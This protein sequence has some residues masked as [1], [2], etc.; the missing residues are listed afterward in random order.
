MADFDW[1]GALTGLSNLYGNYQGAQTANNINNSVQGMLGQNAS[2]TAN[3]IGNISNQIGINR[4]QAQDM[5]NNAL[6][7]YGQSNSQLQGNIG[8]MTNQLNALSDPN[9]PYMQNA[10]QAIERKDA[11]AGR[12][13]QWGER[14]VQLAGTL[15]DYVGKYGSSMQNSITG[16]Q[17]QINQNNQG[18]ASL[19]SNA[20]APADRNL[21]ALAQMLQQQQSGAGAMNTTG[22]QAANS[23]TNNTSSLLNSGISGLR[24]LVGNNNSTGGGGDYGTSGMF[25]WNSQAGGMGALNGLT[26]MGSTDLF[27][28]GQGYF[29]NADFGTTSSTGDPYA[30]IW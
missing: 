3:Q 5:Y 14:E 9:S 10:R 22:R 26:G 28:Y 21:M 23:A 24:T 16:M 7:Q 20:N 29:D 4:Q 19:Y 27:G 11:A 15:A 12:R 2:T 8:N 25:D 1:G 6:G 13:S 30:D 17:N 18:L